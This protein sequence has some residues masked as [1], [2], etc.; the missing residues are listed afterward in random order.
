ML[1][2]TLR[3]YIESL[4]EWHEVAKY[5]CIFDIRATGRNAENSIAIHHANWIGETVFYALRIALS[6]R[7]SKSMFGVGRRIK[8]YLCMCMSHCEPTSWMNS[9]WMSLWDYKWYKK[10]TSHIIMLMIHSV[11]IIQYFLDSASCE[12]YVTSK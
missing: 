11:N 8:D 9:D 7:F 2:C 6:A 10:N 3:L 5:Y 12:C 1:K 4:H